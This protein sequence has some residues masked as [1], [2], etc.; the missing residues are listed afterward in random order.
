MTMTFPSNRLPLNITSVLASKENSTRNT[1]TRIL[2]PRR[3]RRLRLR[4]CL[5]PSPN[6]HISSKR[7]TSH[8]TTPSCR[9]TPKHPS[10]MINTPSHKL[11][12]KSPSNKK[13]S[14]P[15]P[16]PRLRLWAG[17]PRRDPTCKR[18]NR[19]FGTPREPS[20]TNILSLPRPRRRRRVPHKRISDDY[21][22]R[23]NHRRSQDRRIRCHRLIRRRR[24][25]LLSNI[26]YRNW[27]LMILGSPLRRLRRRVKKDGGD[28][29]IKVR[30]ECLSILLRTTRRRYYLGWHLAEVLKPKRKKR[31]RRKY[32]IGS[33]TILNFMSLIKTR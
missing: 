3:S 5:L 28:G 33:W 9:A 11:P 14:T 22:L 16:S 13:S 17:T 15:H 32:S 21:L 19:R 24:I 31:R 25:P 18:C 7:P 10:N 4:V 8:P 2:L 12:T 23:H 27:I 20:P 1:P 30:G 29:I 26:S 6:R